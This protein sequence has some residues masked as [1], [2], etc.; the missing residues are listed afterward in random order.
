MFMEHNERQYNEN[1]VK[2]RIWENGS[3]EDCDRDRI[4]LFMGPMGIVLWTACL[5]SPLVHML[6]P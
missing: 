6:K 1:I 5:C 3:N 2:V 4:Q